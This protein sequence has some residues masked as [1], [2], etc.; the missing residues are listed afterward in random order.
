MWF[1]RHP[2]TRNKG[3]NWFSLRSF[4]KNKDTT[5]TDGLKDLSDFFVEFVAKVTGDSFSNTTP[6]GVKCH[7][8][9]KVCYKDTELQF[10][11]KTL[12]G[13]KIDVEKFKDQFEYLLNNISPMHFQT[14]HWIVY[15][16]LRPPL[17][18]QGVALI[19]ALSGTQ[20][21]S[22]D[23]I[24]YL[25]LD[26]YFADSSS[27]DRMEF[28]AKCFLL[29]GVKNYPELFAN[30]ELRQD[31][32]TVRFGGNID[33]G[34]QVT[35]YSESYDE[36]KTQ[37][38]T[39]RATRTNFV[40]EEKKKKPEEKKRKREAKKRKREEENEDKERE[41]KKR[42]EEKEREKRKREEENEDKEREK[43]EKK[44][45]REA[46]KR[47]EEREKEEKEREKRKR[48]ERY[49]EIAVS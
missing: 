32:L 26:K 36:Q 15:P 4:W 10:L 12:D 2:D 7:K 27:P 46:K 33:K 40:Q 9:N 3:M 31:N 42:K 35:P 25:H 28:L 13:V 8:S 20:F 43:E 39:Q 34:T 19:V 45:K 37:T 16:N 44:R 6:E 21:V 48:E 30:L 22:E 29:L 17:A 11:K 18:M 23:K 14:L 5:F 47:E 24:L 49:K 41:R 1:S 38:L